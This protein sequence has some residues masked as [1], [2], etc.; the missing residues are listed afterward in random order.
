MLESTDF[1]P[2]DTRARLAACLNKANRSTI[3]RSTLAFSVPPNLLASPVRA[4]ET[5]SVISY[6]SAHANTT[7]APFTQQ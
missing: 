7:L 5:I 6:P 1:V 2:L 4:W 3:A